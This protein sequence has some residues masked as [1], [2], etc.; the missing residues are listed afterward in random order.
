MHQYENDLC[1]MATALDPRFKLKFFPKVTHDD[2]G[3]DEDVSEYEKFSS[4]NIEMKM[5]AK[6]SKIRDDINSAVALESSSEDSAEDEVFTGESIKTYL[7]IKSFNSYIH[8]SVFTTSLL[9]I[10]TSKGQKYNSI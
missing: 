6:L 4:E 2:D 9:T 8:Y 7:K 10:Q 5:V 1:L 3:N